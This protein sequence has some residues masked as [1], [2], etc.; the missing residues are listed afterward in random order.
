M[1]GEL[2]VEGVRL[3]AVH[4]AAFKVRGPTGPRRVSLQ[5][6]SIGVLRG[7]AFVVVAHGPVHIANNRLGRV[8]TAALAAITVDWFTAVNSGPQV[9]PAFYRTQSSSW[10]IAWKSLDPSRVPLSI[11]IF[12]QHRSSRLVSIA[13]S[14]ICMH[15]SC[16]P[17]RRGRVKRG[18]SVDRH[19]SPGLQ[20][21]AM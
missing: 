5:R 1:R 10:H 14:F 4:S 15:A 2:T 9:G 20:T 8:E 3:D 19:H 7:E 21:C 11:C 12:S 18:R 13:Y 17:S 6:N 16:N